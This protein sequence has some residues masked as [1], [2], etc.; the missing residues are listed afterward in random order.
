MNWGKSIVLV[1]I[2]FAGFIGS[3]VYMMI[4]QR[5]DLVRDDYYQDEMVY[6]KQIDRVSRTARLSEAPALVINPEK[7]QID[8]QLPTG[9]STGKLTFYRPSDRLQDRTLLLTPDQQTVSTE[10]LAKGLWRAQVSW[11]VG[12]QE[13]YYEQTFTKP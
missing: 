6:Q 5:V 7:E 2:A 12:D 3:M 9:W 11:S 8:L 1:F 4:N 10:K 13:Y